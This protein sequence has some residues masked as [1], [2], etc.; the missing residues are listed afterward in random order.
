MWEGRG[1]HTNAINKPSINRTGFRT[2]I[3]NGRVIAILKLV[4]TSP[5]TS[6]TVWRSGFPVSFLNLAALRLR[7]TTA[8]NPF[9]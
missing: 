6:K 5:V 7:M 9:R 3:F 1:A 2:N 4:C 8:V